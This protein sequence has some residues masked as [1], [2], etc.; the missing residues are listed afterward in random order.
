MCSSCLWRKLQERELGI[1]SGLVNHSAELVALF[2]P[3]DDAWN[4][5]TRSIRINGRVTSVRLENF[6]WRII[7]D[8]ASSQNMPL[9]KLMTA[10]SRIAKNSETKHTNFTS[11]LRVCCGSYLHAQRENANMVK[12]QGAESAQPECALR[13]TGTSSAY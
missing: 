3:F 11:F 2:G 9:P 5:T 12:N 4:S 7:Y 10:L 1:M 8:I 13:Q 6:Y